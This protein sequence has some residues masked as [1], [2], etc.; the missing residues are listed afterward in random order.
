MSEV[1]GETQNG[2]R[3]DGAVLEVTG[4][5]RSFQQGGVTIHV[6]RG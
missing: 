3:G 6:L 1:A 2:G 5:K 4:L